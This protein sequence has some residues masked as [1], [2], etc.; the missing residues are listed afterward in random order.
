MKRHPIATRHD[1]KPA[2]VN[3]LPRLR[4]SHIDRFGSAA[5][6]RKALTEGG[7]A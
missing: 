4:Q 2:Y 6:A 3:A 5:E 7:A 1:G